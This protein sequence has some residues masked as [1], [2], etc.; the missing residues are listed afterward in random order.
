M[1]ERATQVK[2]S[3]VQSLP[4]SYE[5]LLQNI[6]RICFIYLSKGARDCLCIYNMWNVHKVKVK[7]VLLNVV[8]F[9][10]F[11][12]HLN[13]HHLQPS[14]AYRLLIWDNSPQINTGTDQEPSIYEKIGA[15]IPNT[16]RFQMV[17][18]WSTFKFWLIIIIQTFLVPFLNGVWS[19]TKQ[20]QIQ[21]FE[22]PMELEFECS[23]F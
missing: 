7:I 3:P 5:T 10:N 4:G 9:I 11:I 2:R 14:I 15:W 17:G 8:T 1:S 16:F 12:K 22:F 23:E 19:E 20:F 13:K 21:M 18:V 6:R